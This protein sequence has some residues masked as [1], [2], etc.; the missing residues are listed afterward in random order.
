MAGGY[1][2]FADVMRTT[3]DGRD[4]NDLFSELQ[5]VALLANEQQQN[6]LSLLTYPTESP[7]VSVLQTLGAGS[8][9]EEAS[10]YGKPKS[11]RNS[12]NTLDM[13]ATFKW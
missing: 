6:F 2:A 13:G 8:V 5:Q 7:I 11:N 12:P 9:F 4:L 3:A 10:K 1:S